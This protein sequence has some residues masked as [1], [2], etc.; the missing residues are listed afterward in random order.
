MSAFFHS[1]AL[2]QGRAIVHLKEPQRKNTIT[3]RAR[4]RS[5]N[6]SYNCIQLKTTQSILVE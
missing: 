4:A 6:N 1:I 5:S 3:M 2:E